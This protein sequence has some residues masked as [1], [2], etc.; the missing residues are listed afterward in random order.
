MELSEK[1]DIIRKLPLPVSGLPRNALLALNVND[2]IKIRGERF[3]VRKVLTYQE[4]SKKGKLKSFKWREYQ[5]LNLTTFEDVFLEVEDDDGISAYLTEQ[6][7]QAG[8][9]DTP[10]IGPGSKQIEVVGF[11]ETFYLDEVCFA[12]FSDDAKP[13]ETEDVVLLDYESEDGS[14]LLGVEVWGEDQNSAYTYRQIGI[15]EVEVFAH[16]NK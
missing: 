4:M 16:E 10:G 11:N 2:G 6:K 5:L 15:A 8:R 7:I 3:S 14:V 1:I 9:I 13:D 12:R